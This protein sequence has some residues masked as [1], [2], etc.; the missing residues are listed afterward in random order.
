MLCIH[1]PVSQ[2]ISNFLCDV[3]FGPSV[4]TQD[5]VSLPR[6]CYLVA[7]PLCLISGLL[8]LGLEESAVCDLNFSNV[9]ETVLQP[10]VRSSW[11]VP[12][13]RENER[14]A[15]VARAL[16]RLFGPGGSTH[17]GRGLAELLPL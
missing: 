13:A 15:A 1:F 7:V 6:V 4:F 14:S 12:R 3:C 16:P 11:R 5:G 8:P 9:T 10:D 17:R 2:S